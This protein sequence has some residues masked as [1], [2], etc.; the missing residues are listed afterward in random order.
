MDWIEAL[1]GRCLR[2]NGDDIEGRSEVRIEIVDGR[3]ALR[4]AS[5]GIEL[6]LQEAGAV[7]FRRWLYERRHETVDLLADPGADDHT[8][9]HQLRRHLTRSPRASATSPSPAST[10]SP[11]C[12]IR[13]RP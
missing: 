12:A 11:C 13:R 8:L 4:F 10:T 3:L 1:G 2:L 9:H 6:P 5:E 7:W